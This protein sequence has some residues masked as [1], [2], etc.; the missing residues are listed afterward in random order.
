MEEEKKQEEVI[1]DYL[2]NLKYNY[3]GQGENLSPVIMMSNTI[4]LTVSEFDYFTKVVNIDVFS[5]YSSMRVLRIDS[6]L[7]IKEKINHIL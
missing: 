1:K 7:F 2:L 6:F 5:A 3:R 4:K